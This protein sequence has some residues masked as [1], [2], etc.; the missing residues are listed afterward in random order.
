MK[1]EKFLKSIFIFF[2]V[3]LLSFKLSG[4]KN[5]Y[6]KDIAKYEKVFYVCSYGGSGSTFLC[7]FLNRYGLSVHIHSRIPPN[8]LSS[9]RRIEQFDKYKRLSSIEIKK[10]KVIFIYRNPSWSQI[11]RWRVDHFFNIGVLCKHSIFNYVKNGKD[12]LKYGEF[13]DNYV[14][15]KINEN[16]QIIAI[17]YHHLWDNLPEVFTA[18]DLPLEDISKFPPRVEGS[19]SYLKQKP[20]EWVVEGLNKIN[21]PLIKKIEEMPAVKVL[22][23]YS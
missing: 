9:V 1:K 16:Y 13:F 10:I 19:S 20:P 21:A 15:K 12:L 14:N 22:G 3:A 2:S 7:E 8:Y 4:E 23:P 18:L 11:S 6:S 5:C 17:N